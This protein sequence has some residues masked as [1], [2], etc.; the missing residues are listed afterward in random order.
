MK[1]LVVAWCVMVAAPSVAGCAGPCDAGFRGR[2]WLST[3]AAAP[4]ARWNL[5]GRRHA[6]DG[7]VRRDLRLAKWRSLGRGRID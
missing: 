7:L 5:P 4:R 1:A 2:T 6:A 3:D